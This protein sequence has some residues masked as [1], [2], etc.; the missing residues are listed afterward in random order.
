MSERRFNEDEVAAIFE[1]AAEAQQAVAKQLP[2]GDGMTLTELQQIGK[3]VGLSPD[4][5]AQAARSLERAGQPS[6]RRFLGLPVGVGRTVELDRKLTDDEWERLV[7]DLRETFDARGVMKQEGSLRSW[8]NGNLQILLEPSDTGQRLRMRTVRAASLAWM[9]AGVMVFGISAVVVMGKFLSGRV[10]DPS[11]MG[12]FV[13]GA[14]TFLAGALRLPSW[15]KER[16]RQMEEIAKRI[17]G[18]TDV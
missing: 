8:T 18:R 12:L 5:V 7:V 11:D 1:R 16:R 10:V 4:L 17:V 3:E 2:S 14:G 6:G 15:A 9:S 13:I